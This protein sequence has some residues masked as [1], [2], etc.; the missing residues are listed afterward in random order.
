IGLTNS[1]QPYCRLATITMQMMPKMSWPQRVAGEAKASDRTA[2]D[3][4]V[5]DS[6]HNVFCLC[7]LI[8][9]QLTILSLSRTVPW[10][11]LCRDSVRCTLFREE[12]TNPPFHRL[13]G[14]PEGLTSKKFKY[15]V[16]MK[17]PFGQL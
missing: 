7:Y 11:K 9:A 14:R 8:C 3:A 10:K 2:V 6:S 12:S 16:S 1:V 17:V 15:S 5:I 4:V 13:F